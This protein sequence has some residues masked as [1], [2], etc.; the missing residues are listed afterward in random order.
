MATITVR[1]VDPITGEPL[2]GN[3]Q[4]NFLFDLAAIV[5]IIRTRLL[6]F[7]GEWFLNLLDGLPMFQSILGSSGSSA[8]IEVVINIICQRIQ[9]TPFV[10]SV[11]RVVASYQNRKFTFS[12]EAETPFGTVF[13]SNV[14]GSSSTLGV[15][16]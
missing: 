13:I 1:A 9:G 10:N 15:S 12:A 14:P 4:S 11:N 8:N 5:Q 2:Q 6:L 3:G 7:T 16:S